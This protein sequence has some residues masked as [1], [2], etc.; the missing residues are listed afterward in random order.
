MNEWLIAVLIGAA[1]GLVLGIKI[2]R[3]SNRKEPVLGGLV[4]HIAHY[5]ACAGMSSTVPFIITGI[6]VGLHFLALFLTAVGF[7]A[8]TGIMLLVD[9]VIERNAPRRTS[10]P[11][12]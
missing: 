6:I 4:A 3:D 10:A 9:A 2:A 5:F 1:I 7:L 12:S 8:L 11:A